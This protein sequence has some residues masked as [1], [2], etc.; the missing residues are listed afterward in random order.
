MPDI[1]YASGDVLTADG[2][3]GMLQLVE[4]EPWAGDDPLV[5][6]RPEL[7]TNKPRLRRTTPAP[8]EAATANP[9]E[10]RGSRR[11]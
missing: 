3:G 10:S 9:G 6:A 5:R 2:S 7:F 1:V 11:G 4:G 8:V